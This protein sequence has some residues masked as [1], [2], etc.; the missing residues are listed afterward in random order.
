MYTACYHLYTLICYGRVPQ[1]PLDVRRGELH[2]GGRHLWVLITGVCSR[3]GVQRMGVLSY[4]I[5]KQ[6]II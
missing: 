2:A 3:R 4:N 5:I 6:P 1:T